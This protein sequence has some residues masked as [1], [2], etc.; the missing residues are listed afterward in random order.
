MEVSSFSMRALW[1]EKR[2]LRLRD[3]APAPAPPAG[4]ALIRVLRAGICN[5]DLELVRGYYPFSGI[6][7][8]EFVGRVEAAPG[9]EAWV[10]RRVVGEINAVCGR[11]ET[12]R[13]G[14]HSHC[15]NRTVLGIKDRNG[16]FAEKLTLP[17]ENLH[18]VPDG[19][20]DDVAV[21][22]EPTAAALELQGQ[23]RIAPGDRVVVV[24]DGKL[25][26]I[27]AQTLALT[28]CD[29]FV[30]GRHA[31]KLAL[32]E[33]RGIRVGLASDIASRRA[34]VVVECTGNAEGLTLAREAV[35]P[36]G[37]IVLKSTYSGAVTV[38]LAPVVV[39][40]VT[41]VGSRCGPFAPAL[42]LLASGGINVR[43]LIHAHYALA[44]G[45]AAF[46]HAV[47]PGVLKVLVDPTS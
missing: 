28:G 8:H 6:P 1:L 14:R 41:L 32:L 4:E 42:E 36:R 31:A 37:T 19:V 11:C 27:I 44:D 3:D 30:V 2:T 24:G 25:G 21:F 38:D 23:V 18:A 12:C 39:D 35:R 33:A 26:N 10:E 5:T 9:N 15:E 47:R 43:P 45:L 22:T 17:V 34:D 29:L 20:D 16:A 13:A 46:D 40:E 7:G